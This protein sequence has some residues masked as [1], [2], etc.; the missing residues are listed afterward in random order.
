MAPT[1]NKKKVL[2]IGGGV[3]G[4]SAAHEFAKLNEYFD[5]T[6]LEKSKHYCGGKARSEKFEPPKDVNGNELPPLAPNQFYPSEHGFRFFPG[7]YKNLDTTLKEIPLNDK[8]GKTVFDNL[9]ELENYSFLFPEGRQMDLPVKF[10]L[11]KYKENIKKIKAQIKA[12]KIDIT[13]E[14]KRF[15][16][17]RIFQMLSSSFERVREEYERIGWW[18][19]VGAD[20]PYFG[21]DYKYFMAEGLTRN[22]VAA[23]AARLSVRTAS[24]V[25]MKMARCIYHPFG[26][27]D[28]I[29]NAPTNDAWLN[30]WHTH[31]TQKG[32]QYHFN[33]HVT[34]IISEN[35]HQGGG[36]IEQIIAIQNDKVATYTADYYLFAL[37]VEAINL[38]IQKN[39]NHTS[40]L[41]E[42][43]LIKIDPTLAHLN[44][45]NNHTEWMSGVV[46]YLKVEI[47]FFNGHL[48]FSGSDWALTGVAQSQHWQS[49]PANTF[50]RN[51][52]QS[53]LSVV[54]SDWNTPSSN[55]LRSAKQMSREEVKMEV[56]HQVLQ[57]K[58][59]VMEN[60][61]KRHLT[62]S[63]LVYC[64]LDNAI[65]DASGKIENNE[66]LLVNEVN[67][68]TLRPNSFTRVSNMFL[69]GDYVKNNMDLATMEGANESA[70][71]AVNAILSNYYTDTHR[72]VAKFFMWRSISI[73][74]FP[75][76][77][78][79]FFFSVLRFI[80]GIRFKKGKSWNFEKTASIIFSV[81][82][83][84]MKLFS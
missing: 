52:V 59:E 76:P 75:M 81:A 58:I 18:E 42:K 63:D 39:A 15:F 9:V 16:A 21:T 49:N 66:P 4:M 79:F 22:L 82:S 48:T 11:G 28:R 62:Q 78:I 67:T 40:N 61:T 60:G 84:T 29:L 1:S 71:R 32:I 41:P 6:I 57:S 68:W 77:R 53:I 25:L 80:D 83:R 34:N 44:V 45:L 10:R 14:G 47:E 51:D 69:A 7:F 24:P 74:K 19:F 73:K 8:S 55:T 33:T 31:L 56:W 12:A 5:V 70:K 72:Y 30:H 26:Q 36:K 38:L 17:M 27:A 50:G 13:D 43:S 23:Q 46:F 35:D 3:A 2:I 54:I 64:Y 20:S 37:P 65:N